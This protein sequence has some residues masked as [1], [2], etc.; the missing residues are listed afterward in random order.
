MMQNLTGAAEYTEVS[1]DVPANE[2]SICRLQFK[3]NTDP[4]K[5]APRSLSGQSPYTFDISRLDP[6]INK[7]TDSWNSHPNITEHYATFSLDQAGNVREVVNK[8]FTCPKGQVAQFVLHP[9]STRNFDYYWFELDY[10]AAE[11]GP[12]G[13]VLEMHT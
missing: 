13:I 6:S 3:I 9:S 2:A 8:W 1:F 11:G 10:S 5:N 12:H 4:N 7:N